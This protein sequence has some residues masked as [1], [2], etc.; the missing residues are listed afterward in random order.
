VVEVKINLQ[1][2]YVSKYGIKPWLGNRTGLGKKTASSFTTEEWDKVADTLGFKGYG[3]KEFE[4]FLL[5][6]PDAK[7]I[8]EKRHQDLYKKS[9]WIDPQHFGYG[10]AAPELK[11]LT[12]EQ[13]EGEIPIVDINLPGKGFEEDGTTTTKETTKP[14]DAMKRSKLM[15]FA[16]ALLPYVR[17]SDQEAFDYA[18]VYPEMMAMAMNQLEPVKAQLYRPDLGT[19]MDISLQDQLNANQADF[20]ALQRQVG[21]N[22]AALSALAAQKYAANQSVLGEQFRMNQAEKQR[23]Y[24]GNRALLNQAQLQNLGILDQ[25]FTRQ[26]E[27]KS[28]TKA[29][30]IEAMKSI[31]DKIAQNKLENRTLGIYEN[32]YNYRYDKSGRAINMNPL[33]QFDVTR[34]GGGSGKG[35]SGIPDDW[36]ALYDEEGNFQGTKKRAKKEEEKN[37]GKVKKEARNGNIV[38]AIKNL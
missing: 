3:N 32:L 22:P 34:G 24:E 27:A 17:P 23:V 20:N 2:G 9:P 4:E 25:Q 14:T 33:A 30:A 29:Q 31:A 15:D 11:S 28:K 7:K 8:I 36:V 10:W 35:V 1:S 18:Q 21:Y 16:N 5:A 6:N 12:G 38:K 13:Y 19:P 37:G 26:E